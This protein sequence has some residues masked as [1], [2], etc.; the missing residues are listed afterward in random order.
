MES[1]A[2]IISVV[3]HIAPNQLDGNSLSAIPTFNTAMPTFSPPF[4]PT[5]KIEVL[6]LISSTL[7]SLAPQ[8]SVV[9]YHDVFV[10]L[11]RAPSTSSSQST[12]TTTPTTTDMTTSTSE[13]FNLYSPTNTAPLVPEKEEHCE[14]FHVI[15]ARGAN[16]DYGSPGAMQGL[17]D[18]IAEKKLTKAG[19]EY[20][21]WKK[22]KG[23]GMARIH[24]VDY[25]ATSENYVVSV[26]E[27]AAEVK[28]V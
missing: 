3:A 7:V 6:T 8:S 16:E 14:E 25:P 26:Q 23:N 20:H 5:P 13:E 1:I 12:P 2:I 10:T 28:R 18:L 4:L 19:K 24:T 9:E 15:V 22:G 21:G 27:G 11:T 17:A